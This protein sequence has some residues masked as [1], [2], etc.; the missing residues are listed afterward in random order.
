MS[1][2]LIRANQTFSL[3]TA[4]STAN[5]YL[6]ITPKTTVG[7]AKL[8]LFDALK[9]ARPPSDEPILSPEPEKLPAS[10]ADI[11]L[12]V[13]QGDSWSQLKDDSVVADKWG[14]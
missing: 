3:N 1:H 11:A 2:V 14:M 13:A 8:I 6:N 12:F 10:A 7:E 5:Y 9:A 4:F